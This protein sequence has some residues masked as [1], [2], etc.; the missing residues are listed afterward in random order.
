MYRRGIVGRTQE[1]SPPISSGILRATDPPP[2]EPQSDS[3]FPSLLLSL[4]SARSRPFLLQ[5]VQYT[6]TDLFI[7]LRPGARA[8]DDAD[9][10]RAS[11]R[12]AFASKHGRWAHPTAAGC[13]LRGRRESKYLYS[14]RRQFQSCA[15]LRG[16]SSDAGF[17]NG[18]CSLPGPDS[19]GGVLCAA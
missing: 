5:T 14:G 19:V 18:N 11:S 12:C 13:S 8:P 2:F 4:H 10:A 1:E 17:T 9:R 15:E 16:D 3:S 6:S 7:D